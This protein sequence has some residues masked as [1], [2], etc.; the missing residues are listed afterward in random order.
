MK[1]KN[2]LLLV[3]FW[4]SI[5][6]SLFVVVIFETGLLP[7]GILKSSDNKVVEFIAVSIMELITIASIPLMLRFFKFKKIRRYIDAIQQDSSERLFKLSKIRL[8]VLSDIMFANTIIY[9]L[10]MNVAFGYM[11]IIELLSMVFIY[12]SVNRFESELKG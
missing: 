4:F 5:A 7:V 11:A 2:K 1:E 10:F 3:Q 9:Y 12:P 8:T 6:V